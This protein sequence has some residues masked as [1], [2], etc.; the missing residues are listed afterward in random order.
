V[1]LCSVKPNTHLRAGGFTLIELL[2]VIS[3]I[4]L[5][6][7][8]LL[9][10]LEQS[11]AAAR[12]TI[13]AANLQQASMSFQ[14][15]TQDFDAFPPQNLGSATPLEDRTWHGI[16]W[17]SGYIPDARVFYCPVRGT[18]GSDTIDAQSHSFE[19]MMNW[20]ILDYGINLAL[21]RDFADLPSA[22]RMWMSMDRVRDPAQTILMVESIMP[23][24]PS[25]GRGWVYP[26]V[27]GDLAGGQV[28]VVHNG[29]VN[30]VWADSHVSNV[31][32]PN[33]NDPSAIYAPDVLTDFRDDFN[34]WLP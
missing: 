33:P 7:A 13:C 9:P 14:Y 30:V 23:G 12:R 11:R 32:S 16:M 28:H 5:L 24:T 3:I 19:Y 10:A 31:R 26:Y 20:G 21:D 17:H 4:A 18:M 1:G 29:T 2:V 34:Y 27:S 22:P 25:Q 6:I 15:Y 8:I